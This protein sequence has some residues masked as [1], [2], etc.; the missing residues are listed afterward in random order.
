MWMSL[1]SLLET[2]KMGLRLMWMSCLL[3][4]MGLHNLFNVDVKSTRNKDWIRPFMSA[5]YECQVYLQH[6]E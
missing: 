2:L 5:K 1:S 3:E 6:Q 4:N